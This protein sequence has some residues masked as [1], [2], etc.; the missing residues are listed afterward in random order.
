VII[1]I[2]MVVPI[3]ASLLFIWPIIVKK[4]YILGYYH[5]EIIEPYK[6]FRHMLT[7]VIYYII[8]SENKN[9]KKIKT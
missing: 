2:R 5:F 9:I 7:K 4:D 8:L 6:L 1:A 3:R